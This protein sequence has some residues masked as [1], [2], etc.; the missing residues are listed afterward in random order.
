MALRSVRRDVVC[1]NA[2]AWTW[3]SMDRS[4][5]LVEISW[6]YVYIYILYYI[7]LYYIIYMYIL[8]CNIY[9]LCVINSDNEGSYSSHF[10]GWTCGITIE[11]LGFRWVLKLIICKH[12]H[13][14]GKSNKHLV[15][16]RIRAS[17][18]YD[19]GFPECMADCISQ[20]AFGGGD[21]FAWRSIWTTLW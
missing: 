11:N 14:I 15:L 18:E 17:H 2:V 9:I 19:G 13:T 8:M 10:W 5:D 12:E 7:I 3:V 20:R 4:S 16:I 6:E 21:I 1:A